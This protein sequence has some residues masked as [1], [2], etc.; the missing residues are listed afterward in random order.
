MITNGI[1]AARQRML[2]NMLIVKMKESSTEDLPQFIPKT[3]ARLNVMR[4]PIKKPV[5][6]SRII[7]AIQS[8]DRDIVGS[9]PLIEIGQ[10]GKKDCWNLRS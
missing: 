9:Y 10:P 4:K 2:T 3:V 8:S 1:P 7:R 6:V 5:P